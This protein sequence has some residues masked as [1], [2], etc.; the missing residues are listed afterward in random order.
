MVILALEYSYFLKPKGHDPL[1]MKL[2]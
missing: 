1:K 2:I